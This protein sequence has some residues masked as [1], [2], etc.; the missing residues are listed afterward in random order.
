M[1]RIRVL[2]ELAA[3]EDGHA[4]EEPASRRAWALLGYLALHPGA[5]PRSTLAA[6][7]WPDVLDTS[8]RASMRSA[9]WAL[10][11]ALGPAAD[12]VL[13]TARDR[14]GL[15]GDVWIDAVA[16]DS[17]LNDGR[18]ADAVALC[19]GELLSG[20]E[21]D[22]ALQAR[23]THRARLL[24]ALEGLADSA[25]A[26]GDHD[27][28]IGW[29]RRAVAI[30]PFAEDAARLLM[31]RLADAGDRGGA[32]TA[33][34]R[35][36]DRLAR[37]LQA[38]P[39]AATRELAESLRAMPDETPGRLTPAVSP[40][41]AEARR[42]PALIGRDE[43]LAQLEHVWAGAAAGMGGAAVLVAGEAGIGKS[44]LVAELAAAARAHGAIVATGTAP[45]V[46][47]A[48]PFGVWA[49]LLGMMLAATGPVPADAAW[50]QALTPLLPQTAER[51]ES[52][53]VPDLARARLLEASADVL[54]WAATQHGPLLVVLE[55]LH[56]ADPSSVE[57]AAHAARRLAGLP[58]LLVLTR[59]PRP[60]RGDVAAFEQALR[61]RGLLGAELTLAPLDAADI[62]AL[63]RVV[64]PLGD[65]AIADVVAAADG[66]PL[67]ATEAARALGR[68]EPSLPA[69]LR[70][71][72]RAASARL[73]EEAR[74]LV[75]LL[76][77]AGDALPVADATALSPPDALRAAVPAALDAGLLDPDSQVLRFRHALLREATYAELPVTRRM[78]LHESLAR[79]LGAAADHSRA[80]EVARHL[81]LA[82]R[83]A[84]AVEQLRR[85]AAQARA[86]A[87]LDEAAALLDQALA[88][89]PED[90]ELAL[91]RAD[92]D[93]WRHRGTE[94]AEAFW[95]ALAALEQ[96]GDVL[97]VA[98][99][100]IRFAEWHHI[101]LCVPHLA[102]DGYRRALQVL[103]AG[104]LQ[105]T[106][107][108]SSTLASMAWTEA[109]DG[110]PEAAERMLA[111][112]DALPD[113]DPEVILMCD[114]ARALAL[115]RR[116]RFKE[117]YAP[118]FAGA[119]LARSLGRPDFGYSC[120][121]N[122]AGA[123]VCAGELDV[124]MS[125]LDQCAADVAGHGLLAVE[126]YILQARAWVLGRAGAIAEADEA[127]R[128]AR[129]LADRI[130]AD[131]LRA[132]I[133]C[134]RGRL[135][136]QAGNYPAAAELLTAA[137][138][139]DGPFSRPLARLHLA[140]A[141]VRLGREDEAEAELRATTAEPVGPGDWPDTLVARMSRVQ[142]LVAAARG[143][144][145][146]AV[147]RLEEAAA[148]W[149]RRIAVE[150]SG[151][152]A[153]EGRAEA[154][155]RWAATLADIGRP[156]VGT[157]EP[158]RELDVVLADMQSLTITT[159]E[160]A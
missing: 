157:I 31:T 61:G 75:D 35:L 148:S 87:A 1:L 107:E 40:T 42:G 39:S 83:P 23:D 48:P 36:R 44:R 81:R 12:E 139:G 92:V 102:A 79:H 133:D 114:R 122:V 16:F 123:A 58:V 52:G 18:P 19:R 144:M 94:A 77:V 103:D 13:E 43:E 63:A 25:A 150:D 90:P 17:A 155:A 20:I 57:L 64:A 137:L 110:D 100:H 145:P 149:R 129:R 55:D 89:T 24:G 115:I 11:R 112:A 95:P 141:L 91:E 116:G 154:G 130:G 86:V 56:A 82:G 76:A 120:L 143:D 38:A 113:R 73:S 153:A 2:G 51:A 119:K 128:A 37:E 41:A 96:R 131:D 50:A 4:I 10:R 30:D 93:A 140:E 109:I 159:P 160:I 21:D 32:L 142:G 108:R 158:A 146:L 125:A 111:E 3:D 70:G 7:F 106:A 71:A 45:D 34:A 9:L 104:G 126:A 49:E 65:Q 136:L 28:A 88:L 72:M 78:E 46:G 60:A 151:A 33:F 124:A 14:V 97:A 105:A 121:V 5:H 74:E 134:D 138:A 98:R 67:L 29:A 8:A 80:A 47:D 135:A 101:P 62:G 27:T 54:E 53:A 118:G 84:E 85:A 59:R 69:G 152:G 99:A 26:A 127:A 22:W 147:K 15:R 132:A 6:T 156:V 66:N 117:S 68:G